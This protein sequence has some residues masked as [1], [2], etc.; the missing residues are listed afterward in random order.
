MTYLLISMDR[1]DLQCPQCGEPTIEIQT[2][3]DNE[4]WI[5]C[6]TCNLFIGLSEEEWHKIQNS[7][8]LEEKIRRLYHKDHP[9]IKKVQTCRICS[10]HHE[11]VGV[12]GICTPCLY[13]ALIILVIVMVIASFTVWFGIF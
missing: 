4:I 10:S 2:P 5:K 3:S 8:N 9:E 12:G 1:R 13:K 11:T 7:P 6:G